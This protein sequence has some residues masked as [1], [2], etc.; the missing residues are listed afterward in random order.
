MLVRDGR[1]LLLRCY[2]TGT[3]T[4]P[5]GERLNL[6]AIARRLRG[7]SLTVRGSSF[8]NPVA[9]AKPQPIASPLGEYRA[10]GE[11]T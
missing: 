5:D 3:A 2:N 6:T 1:V 8:D 9:A 10:R 7:G 4:G 11:E